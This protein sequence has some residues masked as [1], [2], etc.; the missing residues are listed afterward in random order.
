MPRAKS[1]ASPADP[2][3]ANSEI[4]FMRAA[5]RRLDHEYAVWGRVVQGLGVVRAVK[6]GEP[7][8]DPDRMTRVRVAADLPGAERP[9]LEVL[10]EHGPAFA[11]AV[12]R[13]RQEKGP[14]FSVCDVTIPTRQP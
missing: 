7:P 14:A 8:A 1:G 4:F 9:N 12:G 5:A 2:G 6:V 13:L 11:R 10:N 3:A